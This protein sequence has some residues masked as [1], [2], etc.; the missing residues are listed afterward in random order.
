MF[1]SDVE[2]VVQTAVKKKE[3]MNESLLRYIVSTMLAGAYVGIG[4]VLIF[5]L[6]A[7]LAA[8]GSPFQSLVMGAAFG[9]ALT[10]VVFA[11]SELFTG[12]HMVFTMSTLSGKTT[13]LDTLKNWGIVFIG[14]IA[15]AVLLSYLVAATGLF[16]GI[17]ADHLIFTAAAKKM[18][19]PFL[20]LFFRGI[21]CNWLVCLAIWTGMRAKN[22]VARL[23]LIWWCLF[24]F[25]AT[26]Y[27]HSVANMTLLTL[28]NIL[29]GHP[30]TVSVAG[31]I[32]NMVPVTLGNIVGGGLFVGSA[33]W[34]ISTPKGSKKQQASG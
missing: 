6:G 30:E 10:L 16:K 34:F 8:E 14:N 15:G 25:I 26:G 20:E 28:A 4:I 23:I 22:E 11:G 33:Y 24:A 31:W 1:A 21:L 12:N 29:P 13:T 5:K 7:P 32:S 3:M 18:N 27:E 17:P 9:I 2:A 19:D